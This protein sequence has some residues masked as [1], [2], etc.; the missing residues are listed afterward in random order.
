M[1]KR[2][3]IED[4]YAAVLFACAEVQRAAVETRANELIRERTQAEAAAAKAQENFYKADKE[5]GFLTVERDTV[6]RGGSTDKADK[7]SV[8][9]EQTKSKLAQLRRDWVRLLFCLFDVFRVVRSN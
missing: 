9:V 1:R 7:L 5:L 8:K 4:N 3:E 6:S 2:A